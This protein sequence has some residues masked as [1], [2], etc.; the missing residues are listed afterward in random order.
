[1]RRAAPSEAT[2]TVWSW[3]NCQPENGSRRS[4]W[5]RTVPAD[6][7]GRGTACRRGDLGNRLDG[8]ARPHHGA[9][10]FLAIQVADTG[11]SRYQG[12]FA[13][14]LRQAYRVPVHL[15]DPFTYRKENL[16]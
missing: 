6:C 7:G 2:R 10:A 1:V 11:S 16:E 3:T 8:L 5:N 12:K 4:N 9:L 15:V 13:A 14:P